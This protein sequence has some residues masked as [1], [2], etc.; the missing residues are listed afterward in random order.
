V[1]WLGIH[2][3]F[4]KQTEALITREEIEGAGEEHAVSIGYQ[5]GSSEWAGISFTVPL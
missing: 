2:R 1:A 3:F 5:G 4:R